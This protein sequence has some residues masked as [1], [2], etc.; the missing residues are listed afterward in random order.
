VFASY[1]ALHLPLTD[2]CDAL[3]GRMGFAAYDRLAS[4]G[5][6]VLAVGLVGVLAWYR[7]STVVWA[8][9]AA[10]LGAAVAARQWLMVA[11]IE[12]IHY[13]QYALM[14]FMLW[15]GGLSV[16]ASFLG[17]TV[18]GALDEGYQFLFLPYGR[19][20]YFDWND[21]VLNAL[22]AAF[23]VLLIQPYR[24]PGALPR[25]IGR[26]I[27]VVLGLGFLAALLVSPPTP[28]FFRVA[29]TGRH[30]HVLSASEALGVIGLLWFTIRRLTSRSSHI[31]QMT[32]CGTGAEVRHG[33]SDRNLS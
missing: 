6:A 26:A 21:I 17:A 11:N 13:P 1:L 27:T 10:A 8:S 29:P 9:L 2:L 5:A 24:R 12:N 22:G 7:L 33:L 4:T 3:A 16:E 30:F 14:V 18:L 28:P 15:R 31:S 19:P 23:G 32:A 20:T 25:S